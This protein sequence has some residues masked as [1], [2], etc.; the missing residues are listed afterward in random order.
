MPIASWQ[1]ITTSLW[2]PRSLIS[3]GGMRQLNGFYTQAFNQ[4]H[5]RVG[6]LFQ[7][8][9]KAILVEKEPHLL[10]LT[11]YVVLNPV[12]AGLVRTAKDWNW[13]SYRAT[14]GLSEAP[15]FFTTDRIL[16]QFGRRRKVAQKR[17]RW[18][19]A[20]GKGVSPWEDLRG[21]IYWGARNSSA[22]CPSRG[23]NWRS[24][25]PSGWR[26]VL[27]WPRSLPQRQ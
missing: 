10:E 14:A 8:R 17:Y 20:A 19:V 22:A 27:P 26:F 4:R 15:T 18:F 7:G 16:A 11:R 5:S 24:P 23:R 21:Q 6:H 1:I 9:F 3:L 13:S 2:K 12:R 25:G